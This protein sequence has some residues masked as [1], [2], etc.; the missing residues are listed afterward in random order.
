MKMTCDLAYGLGESE[1]SN[2]ANTCATLI[3]QLQAIVFNFLLV[4]SN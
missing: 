3:V 1:H 4:S 2:V